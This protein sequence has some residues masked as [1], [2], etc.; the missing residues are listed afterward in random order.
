MR[1]VIRVPDL[2]GVE[3]AAAKASALIPDGQNLVLH[4]WDDLLPGLRQSIQADMATGW[5]MFGVLVVIV[6]FSV[7]NTQLMSVLE[8]T[9]EFGI[10]MSLGATPGRL[11]RLVMAETAFLG[12]IGLVIGV[13]A[14]ALLTGWVSVHGF[15][16]PGMDEMAG[17]F[18]LPSR[19][20][21]NLSL[22]SLLAGPSVVFAGSL[23]AAFYPAARM[24]WLHPVQAMRAA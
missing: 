3:S 13:S 4:D 15:T 11:G 8:R 21:P 7:L 2:S 23:M 12:L 5:F 1:V 18:N 16:F 6:S 10:V 20:Y 24:Q 22:I 14:G 19:V 17:R 9:K